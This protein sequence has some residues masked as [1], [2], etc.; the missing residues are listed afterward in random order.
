V[1]AG[2]QREQAVAHI[3]QAATA[4]ADDITDAAVVGDVPPDPLGSLSKVL[5]VKVDRV[6]RRSVPDAPESTSWHRVGRCGVRAARRLL[7]L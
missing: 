2:Q 5:G 7:E 4:A 3:E 6:I 1:R